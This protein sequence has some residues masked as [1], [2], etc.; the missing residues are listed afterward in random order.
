MA[1]TEAERL[2]NKIEALKDRVSKLVSVLGTTIRWCGQQKAQEVLADVEKLA[3]VR[4]RASAEAFPNRSSQFVVE[5]R[6]RRYLR[7][8][9]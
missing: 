9:R 6:R 1:Y 8:K 7:N 5:I 2:R 3:G 4:R